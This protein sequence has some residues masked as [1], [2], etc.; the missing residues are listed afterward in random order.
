MNRID[1]NIVAAANRA[2]PSTHKGSRAPASETPAPTP[3]SDPQ[4]FVDERSSTL[5]S[6]TAEFQADGAP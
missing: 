4:G 1:P 6:T 3:P 5:T 2:Q